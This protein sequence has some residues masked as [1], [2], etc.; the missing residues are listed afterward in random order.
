MKRLWST[1]ELAA[2][3]MLCADDLG[4][5]GDHGE[6]AKLGLICQLAFSLELLEKPVAV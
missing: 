5:T 2:R 4:F 6:E 1:D 3:W